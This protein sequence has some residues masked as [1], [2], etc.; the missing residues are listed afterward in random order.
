[1]SI[2]NAF[3]IRAE[4]SDFSN[5]DFHDASLVGGWFGGSK[6]DNAKF[7]N[8]NLS[9]SDFSSA[10]GLTQAQLSTACGDNTTKLPKGLVLA[11]CKSA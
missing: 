6:F 3:G 8:A 5:V 2:V 4:G 11:A 10:T 7:D 1:M 9:G